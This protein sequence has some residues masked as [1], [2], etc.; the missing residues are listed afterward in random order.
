RLVQQHHQA[1]PCTDTRHDF[2]GLMLGQHHGGNQLRDLVV[3][4]RRQSIVMPARP[5]REVAL[6]GSRCPTT[7]GVTRV[8]PAGQASAQQPT[9]RSHPATP[10]CSRTAT[11]TPRSAVAPS[12]C[13][14][15][16]SYCVSYSAGSI[17]DSATVSGVFFPAV[18]CSSANCARRCAD[19]P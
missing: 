11:P 18:G 16:A 4:G 9:A 14:R 2:L 7:D 1:P 8:V 19:A 3:R 15:S 12:I 6:D 5:T 17:A 13:A 10:V